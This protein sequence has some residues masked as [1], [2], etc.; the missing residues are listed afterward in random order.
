MRARTANRAQRDRTIRSPLAAQPAVSPGAAA[1]SNTARH[2]HARNTLC[3]NAVQRLAPI[4]RKYSGARRCIDGP[5]HESVFVRD[6]LAAGR[7]SKVSQ[8]WRPSWRQ[9]VDACHN[10]CYVNCYADPDATLK[11]AFYLRFLC[12]AKG[13]RTPDLLDAN[14]STWAFVAVNTVGCDRKSLARALVMLAGDGGSRNC[15]GRVAD[16]R[17]YLP[18]SGES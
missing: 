7:F 10:R 3:P 13:N 17:R 12:G 16:A 15:C 14:E 18:D 1:E 2:Q 6:R 8:R 4:G 9:S 5:G 11:S